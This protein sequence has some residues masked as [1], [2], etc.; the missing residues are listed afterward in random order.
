MRQYN[1]SEN[2]KQR[3]RIVKNKKKRWKNLEKVLGS[4]KERKMFWKMFNNVDAKK[5]RGNCLLLQIY[6]D[7]IF[8]KCCEN[9]KKC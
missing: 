1:C 6:V 3:L 9:I 5:C 8:T 4:V 7:K 2:V